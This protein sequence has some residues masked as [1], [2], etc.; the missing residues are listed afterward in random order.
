MWHHLYFLGYVRQKCCISIDIGSS[1]P[2][3]P[4]SL[5]WH[6]PQAE[7]SDAWGMRL[8]RAYASSGAELPQAN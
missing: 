4:M 3:G 2:P 8:A 7:R 5:V 1:A 6:I